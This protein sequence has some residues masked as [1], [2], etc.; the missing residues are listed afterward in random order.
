MSSS[1]LTSRM[2]VRVLPGAL[3]P[4]TERRGRAGLVLDPRLSRILPRACG[5]TEIRAQVVSLRCES[6]VGRSGGLCVKALAPF[7]DGGIVYL[8][9]SGD[10]AERLNAPALKAGGPTRSAGSNPAVS[11]IFRGSSNGKTAVFG[12]E[13]AGFESSPPSHVLVP[14]GLMM[15]RETKDKILCWLDIHTK[16]VDGRCERCGDPWYPSKSPPD[17][18]IEN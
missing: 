17:C 1:V 11:S 8:V 13:N 15:K 18:G 2:W 10:V 9:V 4:R 7:V 12:T 6:P 16:I 5:R 14:G 3:W